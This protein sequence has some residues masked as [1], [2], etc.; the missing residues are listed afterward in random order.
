MLSSELWI[1]SSNSTKNSLSQAIDSFKQTITALTGGYSTLGK[2]GWWR[3]ALHPDRKY[4]AKRQCPER[5][6]VVSGCV[7]VYERNNV[8]WLRSGDSLTIPADV[9]YEIVPYGPGA[10]IEFKYIC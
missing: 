1:N 9:E 8:H 5:I 3:R 6:R 10:H 4:I 7:S 2:N